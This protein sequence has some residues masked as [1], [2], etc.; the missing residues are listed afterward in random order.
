MPVGGIPVV[1]VANGAPVTPGARGIPVTVV[2]GSASVV[3]EGETVAMQDGSG[4]SL[5]NGT[6]HIVDGQITVDWPGG[7]GETPLEDGEPVNIDSHDGATILATGA[8]KVVGGNLVGVLAPTTMSAINDGASVNLVGT[9]G[10]S[11]RGSANAAVAN[12]AL[13]LSLPAGSTIITDQAGGVSIQDGNGTTASGTPIITGGTNQLSYVSMGNAAVALNGGAVKMSNSDGS[14]LLAGTFVVTGGILVSANLS[15]AAQTI[16]AN[17]FSTSIVGYPAESFAT[18][19]VSNSGLQ[20]VSVTLPSTS[21]RVDSGQSIGINSGVSSSTRPLSVVNG[22]LQDINLAPSGAYISAAEVVTV[23]NNGG[24]V[25]APSS[26]LLLNATTGAIDQ[27]KLPANF[28]IVQN[29]V[30]LTVP[31]TGTYTNTITPQVNASGVI[32][33]FTLS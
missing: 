23:K 4:N 15:S 10:H 20:S 17:T 2:G 18:L 11:V 25:T 19:N 22:V 9:D 24:T 21:V 32:T 6:V 13:T 14:G 12:G 16:V 8:A 30:A 28:G 27:V 26:A 1:L 31:V 33:G 5:G 3:T 7:G 29:A